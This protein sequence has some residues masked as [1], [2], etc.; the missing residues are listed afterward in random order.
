VA[1]QSVDEFV[2][3]PGSGPAAHAFAATRINAGDAVVI[4][5]FPVDQGAKAKFSGILAKPL[6][7]FEILGGDFDVLSGY[8]PDDNKVIRLVGLAGTAGVRFPFPPGTYDVEL[9]YLTESSGSPSLS[10]LVGTTVVMSFN[11]E[12]GAKTRRRL[13]SG[14]SISAGDVVKISATRNGG[15]SAKVEKLVF[16]PSQDVKAGA[17]L[18]EGLTYYASV[19]VSDSVPAGSGAAPLWSDWHTTR[20][21]MAGSAWVSGVSNSRGWTIEARL[22][23]GKA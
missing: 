23:V 19:R 5:G 22:S 18:A 3:Q 13:A 16:R 17:K 11:Y 7:E 15:A 12:A 2:S 4:Q 10:L 8:V 20:F 9:A 21:T 14:V 1:G 6:A